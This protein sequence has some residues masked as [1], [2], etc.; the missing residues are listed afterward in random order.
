MAILRGILL[1]GAGIPVLWPNIVALFILLLVIGAFS[2]R[3]VRR[4]L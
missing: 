4:T 3:F 2:L 1:K